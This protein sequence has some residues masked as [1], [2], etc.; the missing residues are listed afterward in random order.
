MWRAD[1][2]EKTLMLGKIEGRRRRRRQ[3]MRGLDSITDSMDMNLGKLWKLV[4]DREAKLAAV[5]GV[6]KSQTQLSD[7]TELN[8]T[9]QYLWQE[10]S[11]W[12]LS[13]TVPPSNVS[14]TLFPDYLKSFNFPS[15]LALSSPAA[16]HGTE[17]SSPSIPRSVSS[18]MPCF[19]HPHRQ[20]APTCTVV[21]HTSV[22]FPIF[23][24]FFFSVLSRWCIL[25][26][27]LRARRISK[28]LQRYPYTLW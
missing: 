21:V 8:W 11:H 4:M 20:Q 14:S 12:Y 1:S 25:T 16:Q 7:W 19:L 27:Y 15:L 13:S 2:F 10:P 22:Y 18:P 5:H 23:E 6:T 26:H 28:P 3:R 24:D 17:G 9:R